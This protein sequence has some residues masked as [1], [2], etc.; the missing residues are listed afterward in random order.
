MFKGNNGESPLEIVSADTFLER[1]SSGNIFLWKLVSGS[2]GKFLIQSKAY[3]VGGGFYSHLW[4]FK[5]SQIIKKLFVH[6][7]SNNRS[8]VTLLNFYCGSACG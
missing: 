1:T 4:V 5:C 7:L 3:D 8:N 6:I 2:K